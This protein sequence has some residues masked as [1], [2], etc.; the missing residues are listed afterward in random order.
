MSVILHML[1]PPIEGVSCHPLTGLLTGTPGLTAAFG[2]CIKT[3][4]ELEEAERIANR[5]LAAGLGDPA[6]WV[7][8]PNGVAVGKLGATDAV[9]F[10]LWRE[11]IAKAGM[12]MQ[13][14]QP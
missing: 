5:A 6:V 8:L 3:V 2:V 4:D 7:L 11:E 10:D 12:A 13:G 14:V 1:D 9:L